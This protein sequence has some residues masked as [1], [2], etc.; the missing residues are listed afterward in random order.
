MLLCPEIFTLSATTLTCN[1]GRKRFVRER[2][3]EKRKYFSKS[4]VSIIIN[5]WQKVCGLEWVKRDAGPIESFWI[6]MSE[7]SAPE[8]TH[9]QGFS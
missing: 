2:A 8:S 6:Q 9:C 7:N 4:H 3:E 1:V 5:S